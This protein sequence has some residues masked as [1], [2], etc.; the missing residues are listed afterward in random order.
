MF[1]ENANIP[2]FEFVVVEQ[3]TQESY[4]DDLDDD[5]GFVTRAETPV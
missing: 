1:F 4:F 2:K 3:P 5:S